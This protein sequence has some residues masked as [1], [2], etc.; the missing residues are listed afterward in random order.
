MSH[1]AG[2]RASA[3]V[4][5]FSGRPPAAS[6]QN[7]LGPMPA[8]TGSLPVM[9]AALELRRRQSARGMFLEIKLWELLVCSR[10]AAVVTTVPRLENEAFRRQLGD[11]R[12]MDGVVVSRVAV[13]ALRR[14]DLDL[15]D[16]HV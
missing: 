1:P 14:W 11:M 2:F 15:V 3:I 10:G 13:G 5:S 6:A 8:R 16:S 9:S 12:G 4:V 7:T